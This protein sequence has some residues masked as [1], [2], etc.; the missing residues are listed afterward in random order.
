MVGKLVG[1]NEEST[2]KSLPEPPKFNLEDLPEPPKL[3]LAPSKES[4]VD[5]PEIHEK[6]IDVPGPSAN[7]DAGIIPPPPISKKQEKEPELKTEAKEEKKTELVK[8]LKDEP[9]L[10]KNLPE[11]PQ[12]QQQKK[13][14]FFSRFF[15]K[16][17]KEEKIDLLGNADM[18]KADMD[19]TAIK[20]EETEEKASD[21]DT[22][23]DEQF[24]PPNMIPKGGS[25]KLP[26][27]ATNMPSPLLKHEAKKEDGFD[28]KFKQEEA[29]AEKFLEKEELEEAEDFRLKEEEQEAEHFI[30]K[31]EMQEAEDFRLKEEEEEAEEF[32]VS[33]KKTP[34]S[35]VIGVGPA[36]E[37]KLNKAGIKTAE[38]L[39]KHKPEHVAKKAK[40]PKK[41]ARK[42]ISH[43]KKITKIKD[44]LKNT[45]K[46]AKKGISDIVKQLEEERKTI[47]KL[48][49][50]SAVS[51]DKIIELEGHQ[52]MIDVLKELEKKRSELEKQE[53][54][55]SEKEMKLSKHDETYKRD[56]DHIEKLKRRLDHDIRERTQYLINLEKE[57]FQKAQNL[58]RKQ[59]EVDVKEKG[60]LERENYL[61]EKEVQVKK[62]LNE[63][64]DRAI[65]IETKEKKFEKI[66]RDL[67]KQDQE[68]REKEDNLMKREAEYLSK[69]DALETHEK[70]ILKNLEERRK[71]LEQKEKEIEIRERKLHKKQRNVDKKSVAV[72]YAEDILEEQ[73][74]KLIDDEFEQY[75]HDQLGMLKTSGISMK[76]IS[77]TKNLRLPESTPHRETVYQLIDTCKELVR[78]RKVAEAKVFYNQVREKYYNTSFHTQKEKEA[79]HNMIRSLYDEINLAAIGTNR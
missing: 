69:L 50:E 20:Q 65:T 52:D 7:T 39:A 25:A 75:L 63:A 56:M 35:K 57:Y 64:E 2:S 23:G 42:I 71:H 1:K 66:M 34:L 28:L 48:E 8:D 36:R 43:A 49:N 4:A 32:I 59:S 79:V 37:K 60:M 18:P 11:P 51:E 68:L 46:Q 72:E 77:L 40:I 61:K 3:E 73:K 5:V 29:E 78:N 67:E 41:H 14:G 22:F 54:K 16:K 70:S 15:G 55:L 38:H 30:E 12:L 45:K 53:R 26:P 76:D 33:E 44:K 6:E 24:A 9:D 58:A 47:E 31:E 62:R 19:D 27:I 17:Q 74:T 13:G 21:Q 10:M